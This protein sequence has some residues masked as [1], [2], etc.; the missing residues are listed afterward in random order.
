MTIVTDQRLIVP[1]LLACLAAAL[2]ATALP[3]GVVAATIVVAVIGIT[4]PTRAVGALLLLLYLRISNPAFSGQASGAEI[5]P[6]SVGVISLLL[7][8]GRIWIDALVRPSIIRES[9]PTFTIPYIVTILILS[10]FSSS[11]PGVSFLK[12][13]SFFVPMGAVIIGIYMVVQQGRQLLPYATTF[14]LFVLLLSIPTLAIPTIGYLRDGTGFQGILNHPQGLAVF[15]APVVIL[16]FVKAMTLAGQR[17]RL[18]IMMFAISIIFLWL[19]RGRTGLVAIGLGFMLLLL[20]RPGFTRNMFTL[21]GTAFAR[22]WVI[23][24]ALATIVVFLLSDVSIADM[25]TGFVFKDAN[26]E[27]LSG[28]F[29]SSRGFLVDQAI[30]NFQASP[31]TGI[32]FGISNSIT[33]AFN[34]QIDPLTGLPVGAATEKANLVLAVIEETGVIGTIMFVPFIVLLLRRIACTPDRSLAWCAMAALC[35]NV[36]EMTFFSFGG[37]GLYTW[38]IMGWA[39]AEQARSGFYTKRDII[40]VQPASLAARQS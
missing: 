23:I 40:A 29:E 19:T 14:W 24:V 25:I 3:M 39:L 33:H 27:G 9:L 26:A 7:C 32:G 2:I 34:V 21:L 6:D 16:S 13:V 17:S 22:P 18:F 8:S 37:I 10:I 4:G 30:T 20:F 11:D 38:L 5:G 35:T 36:S 12:V 1:S 28:A 15:L 31:L